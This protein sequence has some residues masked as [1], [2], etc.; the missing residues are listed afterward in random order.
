M[1]IYNNRSDTERE[2]EDFRNRNQGYAGNSFP[3]QNFANQDT[4][5]YGQAPANYQQSPQKQSGVVY[6]SE[7]LN[8]NDTNKAYVED[9]VDETKPPL[10]DLKTIIWIVISVVLSVVFYNI[11]QSVALLI[12]G[13]LLFGVGAVLYSNR[14]KTPTFIQLIL[15]AMKVLGASMLFSATATL[16][17]G[18][19]E[20]PL[21]EQME[22]IPLFFGIFWFISLENMIVAP[23]KGILRKKRCTSEIMAKVVEVEEH[24]HSEGGTGYF[25]V[26][27]YNYNSRTYTVTAKR[28]RSSLS[29]RSKGSDVILKINPDR[30]YEIFEGLRNDLITAVFMIPFL[31][32]PL[33]IVLDGGR[34]N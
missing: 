13:H 27:Q 23:I 22:F 32:L 30:P 14:Q 29:V 1:S 15:T 4:G 2:L 25:E 6:N 21:L 17:S 34:I 7:S 10:L 9:S 19:Q 31:L 28:Q 18:G 11:N 24:N 16:L 3:N 8:M 5:R 12:F 33:W 20:I 26:Y